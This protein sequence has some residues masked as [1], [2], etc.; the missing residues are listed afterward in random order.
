M[1]PGGSQLSGLLPVTDVFASVTV[2][3]KLKMPPPPEATRP[4]PAAVL[5]FTSDLLRV[6]DPWL[7]MPAPLVWVAV[8]K[9]TSLLLRTASPPLAIPPA[10][11]GGPPCEP[12]CGTGAVAVLPSTWVLFRTR[13]LVPGG[14]P[15]LPFPLEIPPPFNDVLRFTWLLLRVTEPSRFWMPPPPALGAVLPFTWLLFSVRKLLLL[16]KFM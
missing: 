11:I 12:G 8:L 10:A 2:P 16:E 1:L 9:L 15:P 6:I 4:L 14:M 5:P 7:T 3:P 13:W